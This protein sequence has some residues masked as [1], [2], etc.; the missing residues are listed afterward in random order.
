VLGVGFSGLGLAFTVFT[1]LVSYGSKLVVAYLF[2]RLLLQTLAKQYAGRKFLTLFV[3]VVVYAL[4]AWIP[5]LGWLIG[6]VAT[7]IGLGAMWLW[8]RERRVRAA[9]APM[10]SQ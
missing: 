7:L 10:F 6:L 4:V 5:I 3:G 9:P 1:L 2:G 8:F